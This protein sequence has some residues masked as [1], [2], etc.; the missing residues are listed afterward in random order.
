MTA[1][2]DSY[3]GPD[4]DVVS[5]LRFATFTAQIEISGLDPRPMTRLALVGSR[6]TAVDELASR[7]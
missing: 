5:C 4:L 6:A 1:R 2:G 7:R 3:A